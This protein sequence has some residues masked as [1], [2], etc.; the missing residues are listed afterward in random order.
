[1]KI[2]ILI[3]GSCKKAKTIDPIFACHE[4]ASHVIAKNV[5]DLNGFYIVTCSSPFLK[6]TLQHLTEKGLLGLSQGIQILEPRRNIA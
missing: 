4:L 3:S 5:N 6:N 2:K 1:V